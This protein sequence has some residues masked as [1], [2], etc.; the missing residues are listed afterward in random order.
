[1]EF[2]DN[3]ATRG[4]LRDELRKRDE[5]IE[6]LKAEIAGKDMPL[7]RRPATIALLECQGELNL[8]KSFLHTANEANMSLAGKIINLREAVKAADAR[9]D[10]ARVQTAQW[11]RKHDLWK[12]LAGLSNR[13]N[14]KWIKDLT[15]LRRQ[16][17]DVIKD[18]NNL[19]DQ[20]DWWAGVAR[21]FAR[22]RTAQRIVNGLLGGGLRTHTREL[23]ELR[24][25]VA[26][27]IP[28]TPARARD[29]G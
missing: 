19:Q 10:E 8:T 15:A 25:M 9:T 17:S 26:A 16:L 11:Q 20:R 21:Q 6:A 12:R 28:D 23:E 29:E 5:V 14:A 24:R 4:Q 22:L 3:D 13:R 7:F 18:R 1:M 27:M 2:I